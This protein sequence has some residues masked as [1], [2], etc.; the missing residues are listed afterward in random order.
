MI[1]EISPIKHLDREIF[2]SSTSHLAGATDVEDKP[3][4]GESLGGVFYCRKRRSALKLHELLP[5]ESAATDDY[6]LHAS[7]RC[8]SRVA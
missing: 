4:T 8:T 7:A 5:D 1:L 2:I 3:R 6:D